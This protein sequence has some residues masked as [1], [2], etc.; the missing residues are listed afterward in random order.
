HGRLPPPRG[1]APAGEGALRVHGPPRPGARRPPR[2]D[3]LARR[4]GPRAAPHVLARGRRGER[5]PRGAA[6]SRPHAR[7]RHQRAEAQGGRDGVRG[8]DRVKVSGKNFLMPP[9]SAGR[10]DRR[11]SMRPTL[12]I[13]LAL[14]AAL[15]GCA[16]TAPTTTKDAGT[17][18]PASAEA[19][20]HANSTAPAAAGANATTKVFRGIDIGYSGKSATGFCTYGTPSGTC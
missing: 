15:A 16:S 4:D 3:R 7:R 9:G 11:L 18:A 2:A 5:V 17:V 20:A 8:E 14:V 12:A 13:T 6:R 1:R 19:A 10:A